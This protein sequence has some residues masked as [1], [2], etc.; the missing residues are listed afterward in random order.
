MTRETLGETDVEGAAVDLADRAVPERVKVE[1]ALEAGPDLPL[2]ERRANAAG[3]EPL[4]AAADEHRAVVGDDLAVAAPVGEQALELGA[5]GVVQEHLLRRGVVVTPLEDTQADPPTNAAILGEDVADVERDELVL[6]KPGGERHPVQHVVA[7]AGDVRAGD[8]QE[9]GD[10]PLGEGLRRTGDEVSV[11][12]HDSHMGSGAADRQVPVGG[13]RAPAV[14]RSYSDE[15]VSEVICREAGWI[16]AFVTVDGKPLKLQ[17]YQRAFLRNRAPMRWVNK[18]RQVGFSSVISWEAVARCHIL[19]GYTAHIISFGV[20]EAKEKILAARRAFESLPLGV[21]RRL[22]TDSKTELAFTMRN[23]R[24]VTRILAHASES[25][26]GFTGDIYLDELAHYKNDVDA[27]NSS[28]PAIIHPKSRAQ[29]TGC[30]TPMGERGIFWEIAQQRNQR[31]PD[32][33]RQVVP[34]WRSSFLCKDVPA[35]ARAHRD[36]F[37]TEEMVERYGTDALVR[38]YKSMYRELFE[39]EFNAVFLSDALAFFPHDLILPCALDELALADDVT[40]LPRPQGRY[41][42]GYDVAR[43]QDLSALAVFDEHEGTFTCKMLK[44]YAGEGELKF[45]V[46]EEE[47]RR[48][49]DTAP[50]VRLSIDRGGLGMHLTENLQRDF[51]NVIGETFTNESKERWVTNVKILFQQQKIVIPRERKLV[52]D[53]HSITRKISASGKAVYDAPRDNGGHADAFW[54][55]ALAVQR[56]QAEPTYRGGIVTCRIIGGR[57]GPERGSLAWLRSMCPD[58][59]QGDGD[60]EPT[61]LYTRPPVS[62][63]VAATLPVLVGRQPQ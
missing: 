53:F 27:Y 5:D 57:E 4:P 11:S 48:L 1:V 36:G 35:A 42:A 38:Q 59:P 14:I 30:S 62:A 2:R 47:L 43:S 19:T 63:A 45:H 37:S 3:G 18:A 15:Q 50:I 49:L 21:Q 9:V 28:L 58:G 22:V 17:P 31:Y 60:L 8:T 54:A 7:E 46:Q 10:L 34:W 56:E 44:R 13:S 32:H 26:R 23:G 40:D 20:V 39:Q 52:A 12:G 6:A 51:P 16:E 25:I 29:L 33:S 24:G 61:P 55:I 41:V